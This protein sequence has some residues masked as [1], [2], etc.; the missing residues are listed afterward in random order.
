M[1]VLAQ[2]LFYLAW[3]PLLLAL[4]ARKIPALANR[5]GVLLIA[6]FVVWAG[7]VA[8][9]WENNVAAFEAGYNDYRR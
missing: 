3:I 7:S 6:A 4:F 8:V 5:R 1:P 9:D 2:V